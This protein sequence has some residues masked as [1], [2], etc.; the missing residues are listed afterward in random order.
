LAILSIVFT[1]LCSDMLQVLVGNISL[2]IY[3]AESSSE[4]I[5]KIV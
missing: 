2:Q 1:M 3:T 4:R 5:L